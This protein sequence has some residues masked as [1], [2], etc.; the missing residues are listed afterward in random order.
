MFGAAIG[1]LLTL[2]VAKA[3]SKEVAG[4]FFTA[5]SITIFL[6]FLLRFGMDDIILRYSSSVN[7]LNTL[8]KAQCALVKAISIS[9]ITSV[10]WCTL[11]FG[12]Q[13]VLVSIYSNKVV[14]TLQ[15][16]SFLVF[17]LVFVNLFSTFFQ[18]LKF[19]FIAILG[20]AYIP[21]LTTVTFLLIMDDINLSSLSYTYVLSAAFSA[22]T[23]ISCYYFM[24]CGK[25][26]IELPK[27]LKVELKET[28]K[29]TGASSLW[30]SSIGGQFL[31]YGGVIIGGIY[32]N[33]E[34]LAELSVSTRLS[35]LAPLVLV[36]INYT[37][38]PKARELFLSKN[39]RDLKNTY[40]KSIAF[41]FAIMSLLTI[42]VFFALDWVSY[43]LGEKYN[44]LGDVFWILW[45]GQFINVSL[46][47]IGY[48]YI[49]CDR[50]KLISYLALLSVTV[51]CIALF[52]ISSYQS[53]ELVAL[54][55]S[56]IIAFN[57]LLLSIYFYFFNE[58]FF[59]IDKNQSMITER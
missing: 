44:G 46:G 18:G 23:L 39:Y 28:V 50:E 11:V 57:K 48:V 8:Y 3:V 58:V 52:V 43:F 13:D 7:N 51:L 22:I 56:V 5:Y 35:Q 38:A 25:K 32:L 9:I 2:V 49:M 10:I 31:L 37:F 53:V 40:L 16:L 21:P 27:T 29:F 26:S 1:L 24:Y 17:F 20:L 36:I 55:V 33:V 34:S 59:G 47:P 41:C 19:Y 14:A 15:S 12:L 54:I 4:H 6:S 42:F 30:L 45:F